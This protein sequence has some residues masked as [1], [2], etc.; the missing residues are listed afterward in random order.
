MAKYKDG[1]YIALYWEDYPGYEIVKGTISQELF[2]KEI[3][4]QFGEEDM[5]KIDRIAHRY[6]RWGVGVNSDGGDPGQML[7][8][9][10]EKG[11]GRFPITVG[12]LAS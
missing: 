5:P 8:E 11:R 9:Y 3:P 4:C 10:E 7:Y 12:Y 2:E 1:E 6:G